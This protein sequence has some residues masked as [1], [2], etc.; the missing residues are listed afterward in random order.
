MYVCDSITCQPDG[1]HVRLE[2][3]SLTKPMSNYLNWLN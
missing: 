1:A 3:S 2:E